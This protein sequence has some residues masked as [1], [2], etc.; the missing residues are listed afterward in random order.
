LTI[1][2]HFTKVAQEESV[3]EASVAETI[4]AASRFDESS[5][6][7]RGTESLPDFVLAVLAAY[8]LLQPLGLWSEV[9][10]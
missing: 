5:I 1:A 8:E 6:D 4:D 9:R 10:R 2:T 7:R 3:S